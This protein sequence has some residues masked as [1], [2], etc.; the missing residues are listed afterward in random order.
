MNV[1]KFILS[2]DQGTS[3]TKVLIFDANGEAVAKGVQSLKTSYFDNGFVEQDPEQ[4]Y[5][6]VLEA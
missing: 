3:S 4:V 2:I 1:K 6:N 5:Q